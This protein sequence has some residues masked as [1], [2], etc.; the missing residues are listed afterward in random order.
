MNPLLCKHVLGKG[1]WEDPAERQVA[2]MAGPTNGPLSNVNSIWKRLCYANPLFV[3][4]QFSCIDCLMLF[5]NLIVLTHP[6]AN[7]LFVQDQF[8]CIDCLML[9]INLIVL[10]HPK[11]LRVE[12][13]WGA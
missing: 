1:H 12:R 11:K 13:G 7:P 4:D 6:N 3:Q 2:A 5:I 8:S 9:F 10:T